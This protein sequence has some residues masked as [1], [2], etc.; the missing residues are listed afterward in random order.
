M[1]KLHRP[2]PIHKHR[3]DPQ[4]H[5]HHEVHQGMPHVHADIGLPSMI[6]FPA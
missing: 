3:P 4:H 6:T 1:R 2:G 5:L